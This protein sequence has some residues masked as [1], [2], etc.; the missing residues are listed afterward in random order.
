MSFSSTSSGASKGTAWK[1]QVYFDPEA[2]GNMPIQM[3]SDSELQSKL[4]NLIDADEKILNVV[5]CKTPLNESQTTNALLCHVYVYFETNK[6]WWS[7]EKNSEGITIQRAKNLDS[8]KNRYRQT[9]RCKTSY[10]EPE[11][12]I[13]D[14]GRGTMKDLVEF[15]WRK[16]FLNK[17]YNGLFS[18]CKHFAKRVFDKV[19]AASNRIKL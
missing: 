19:S 12:I 9:L 1:G 13:A 18:N 8:V 15:L 17:T 10:W 5:L 16:D 6:F 11:E 2:D 14:E 3:I 7:I 4:M